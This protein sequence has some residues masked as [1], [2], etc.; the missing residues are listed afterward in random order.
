[1]RSRFEGEGGEGR[2]CQRLLFTVETGHEC[3]RLG[4]KGRWKKLPSNP[5]NLVRFIQNVVTHTTPFLVWAF[6]SLSSS[7]Y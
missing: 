3:V 2:K 7:G 4:L 6:C 5:E 1:M